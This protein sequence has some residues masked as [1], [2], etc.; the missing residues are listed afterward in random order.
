MNALKIYDKQR[1]RNK[2]LDTA[3][4][5]KIK[6]ITYVLYTCHQYCKVL[7]DL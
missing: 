7:E 6:S 2:V 1:F 5:A 3:D 4:I